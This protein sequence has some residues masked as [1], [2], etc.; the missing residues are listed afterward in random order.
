MDLSY[1]V[2]VSYPGDAILKLISSELAKQGWILGH[3]VSRISAKTRRAASWENFESVVGNRTYV[4]SQ[5][6]QNSFGD[7]VNYTFWYFGPDLTHLQV[8]ARYCS[9]HIVEKYRCSP[10]PLP[11]HDEKAYSLETK[12]TRIEPVRD[13]F[14]VFV[15]IQNTGAKPVLLGVNGT[16]PDGSPEL[17]VLGLEQEEHGEWS[18]VDAVCAEHPAFD[19]INL[20]P[21]ESIE[22]WALA[23]DLPE[24]NH[25][26]P[27]HHFAKCLRSIGHLHRRD[28]IRAIVRYYTNACE[29]EERVENKDP[30]FA[31]SV[32]VALP[33][34]G[35]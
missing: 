11:T 14:K 22:S 10:G 25:P 24:P 19:W 4:R 28:K 18:D 16:L 34:S 32:P 35:Q 29:I 1:V 26:E 17:W 8:E 9:S 3:S 30:Y 6:W 20:K 23:I 27:N 2:T 33:E 7:V 13:D 15:H 31:A 21:G 5:E 12:I